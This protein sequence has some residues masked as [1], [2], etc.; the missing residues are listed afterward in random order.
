MKSFNNKTTF[1]KIGEKIAVKMLE[2][3]GYEII[4]T[5]F[6]PSANTAETM[7]IIGEIDIIAI[8]RIDKKIIEFFEV[9]TRREN[10][11]NSPDESISAVKIKR[12]FETAMAFIT[13][14]E[15]YRS[16]ALRISLISILLKSEN[17]N[18]F[19]FKKTKII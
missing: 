10:S 12:I 4:C 7:R 8:K 19:D 1:G 17:E 3:D 16:R 15:E 6:R 2:N 13:E 11:I 5:N 14:N 9:R 18:I